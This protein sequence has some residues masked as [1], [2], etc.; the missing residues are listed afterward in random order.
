MGLGRGSVWEGATGRLAAGQAAVP[1]QRAGMGGG[2]AQ[3]GAV[4]ERPPP[5]IRTLLLGLFPIF[6]MLEYVNLL[7]QRALQSSI[8]AVAKRERG[9]ERKR[10]KFETSCSH[11][12]KKTRGRAGR[13]G[14]LRL[15]LLLLLLLSSLLP[16]IDAALT[17]IQRFFVA[18]LLT[19]SV[20]YYL[21]S[22]ER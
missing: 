22:S 6:K 3:A 7:L 12:I 13:V 21:S 14:A 9:R 10:G 19:L 18:L 11:W 15:L 5:F 20:S 2:A 4:P 17:S 8:L 16:L 1:V